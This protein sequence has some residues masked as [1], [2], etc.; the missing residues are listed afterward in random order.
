MATEENNDIEIED[1][2]QDVN[3]QVT[4]PKKVAKKIPK[5]APKKSIAQAEQELREAIYLQQREKNNRISPILNQDYTMIP[6][7]NNK[8]PLKLSDFNPTPHTLGPG[9]QLTPMTGKQKLG[10]GLIIG[11]IIFM[12]AAAALIF[13]GIPLALAVI[14][15]AGMAA[16]GAGLYSYFKN[17]TQTLATTPSE[18]SSATAINQQADQIDKQAQN[19]RSLNPS[20]QAELT[21]ISA[22]L[23]KLAEQQLQPKKRGLIEQ[24]M[25][26][27]DEAKRNNQPFID[28]ASKRHNDAQELIRQANQLI[29]IA[30]TTDIRLKNMGLCEEIRVKLKTVETL[31]S[32]NNPEKKALW[33]EVESYIKYLENCKH[34]PPANFNEIMNAYN[35]RLTTVLGDAKA[36]EKQ[37]SPPVDTHQTRKNQQPHTNQVRVTT[38]PTTQ[39]PPDPLTNTISGTVKN[40][41]TT[42]QPSNGPPRRNSM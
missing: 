37:V 13:G 38:Q 6:A 29:A 11:V 10:V 16:A 21:E 22:K 26:A 19:I 27:A 9:Q 31:T 23:R 28:S 20:Q 34:T 32:A 25:L 24:E 17:K 14:G 5:K 4:P 40:N 36:L 12:A 35:E 3:S 42:S 41:P 33:Q 2:S 7:S 15:L 30:S 8:Q 1:M 39:Q 18:S